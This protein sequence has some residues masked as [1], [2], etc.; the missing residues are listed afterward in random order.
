M[1]T[2]KNSDIVDA[3]GAVGELMK[4]K[5]SGSDLFTLAKVLRHIRNA[6]TDFE[7]ARVALVEKYAM[8]DEDG[9]LQQAEG[10]NGV[11]LEPKTAAQFHAAM[12][13][14][15]GTSVELDFEP[16]S[17][18]FVKRHEIQTGVIVILWWMFKE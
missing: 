17:T 10:E 5:L 13:E 18:A 9:N 6:F 7:T 16:I 11:K 12:R 14:L 3:I 15:L 1:I 4:L 2:V 8:H